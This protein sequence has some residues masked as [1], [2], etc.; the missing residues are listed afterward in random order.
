[1]TTDA[2]NRT[3]LL[4]NLIFGHRA[5]V[6][7]GFLVMT[8]AL[9]YSMTKLE[10]DAGFDKSLPLTHAYMAPFLKYRDEFGAANRILV[11]LTV[12]SGDIFTP[13]FFH[14]LEETTDAVFFIP[15][16]DRSTA[17]SLFTPNVQFTEVVE[18][19]ISGG[20]IV[21]ADFAPTA[22][23]LARVRENLLKSDYVGRLVANDFTGAL[24]SASL[25][26]IDPRTGDRID[27]IRV[28]R[29]L[30]EIRARYEPDDP[31]NAASSGPGP[32]VHI[33][34]FAKVVGDI[35]AGAASVGLFFLITLILTTLLVYLY[36]GSL[37]LTVMTI[38]CSL[39][40]VVWQLGLLPV[41]GYGMD[42][43]SILAPFLVFAI[44]VS[45]AMQMA[46][47]ARAEVLTGKSGF[48]AARGG[49]ARLLLPGGIALVSDAIGFLIILF[50]EI[51]MIREMA[52][53]ASVGVAV[54][55]LTNLLLLPVL[56]SFARFDA[57]YRASAARRMALLAPLWDRLAR[58]SRPRNASVALAMGASLA[59]LGLWKGGDIR[60]G[61]LHAGVPELHADSRYNLDSGII[62]ARFSIGVDVLS[63]FAETENDG[64]ID[65]AVMRN[66]DRF[67]W[68]LRNV[69]GVQS[70]ISLAGLARTINAGWNEGSMK[71]R[72]LPRNRHMMVQSVA[73]VPTSSGL[74]NRDCSV[75]PILIFTADHKAE[76]IDRVIEAVKSYRA[77]HATH[78][79]KYRL[80]GH[81]VGVMAATN[82]AV[83]AARFPILAYVF[84]AIIMLCLVLFRSLRAMLCIVLPLAV[85]SLL[86][87]ALMTY[88]SIGLKVNTLP[89]VALGVGI[90]VDYGIYIFNRLQGLMDGGAPLA[91]AY[92]KTLEI[93][94]SG[95]LFTALILALGVAT[96]IFSDLKFQADMGIMLT[97]IFLVNMLG[98]I[99]LL[100][101]LAGWLY[102][103]DTGKMEG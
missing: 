87:Y 70:V 5:A 42:P 17:R 86:S 99:L 15:G 1:M 9:G 80:A 82:E 43:M 89:V 24:I 83:D 16:V 14:A 100:P 101:A 61:D 68:T 47:A 77:N 95:V 23:G 72:E 75:M 7:A 6:I 3:G 90:G 84:L 13:A 8:L 59:L 67:A 25:L 19:G 36:L 85:V 31:Q 33:I 76:T 55:I 50:I 60:I 18:D 91:D 30:E 35:Y 34:G 63:V 96:W 62:S 37:A 20:N 69:P 97:F 78:G 32:R 79:V 74:L 4:A 102:R 81:N 73:H 94:G 21:P 49:F 41:L 93:T 28:S 66:I 71:W 26:E 45:H 22:E 48:D 64:C 2:S 103:V 12:E 54:I 39:M 27:Y 98:A 38:S 44:A 65:Y 88:L 92:R 10:V 51:E 40:A 29:A 58:I 11:A 53:A 46:S 56:L 57:S 52:I